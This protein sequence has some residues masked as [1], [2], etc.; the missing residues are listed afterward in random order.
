MV[1]ATEDTILQEQIYQYK[2]M[3]P[4]KSDAITEYSWFHYFGDWNDF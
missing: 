4:V 3:E 2:S 1:N